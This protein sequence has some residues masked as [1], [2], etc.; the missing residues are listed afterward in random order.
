MK[1]AWIITQRFIWKVAESDSFL[2]TF[3]GAADEVAG[4]KLFPVDVIS[5]FKLVIGQN[6]GDF[7]ARIR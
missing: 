3:H 6:K 5:S 1:K 4:N 7:F 2:Q